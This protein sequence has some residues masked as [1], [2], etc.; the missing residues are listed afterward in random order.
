MK[1]ISNDVQLKIT[2]ARPTPSCAC[3]LG[4]ALGDAVVE[5]GGVTMVVVFTPTGIRWPKGVALAPGMAQRMAPA[6]EAEW[7]AAVGREWARIRES[8]GA[9]Q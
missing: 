3:G 7:L 5:F 1:L 9:R 2:R 8:A 4:S 6:I